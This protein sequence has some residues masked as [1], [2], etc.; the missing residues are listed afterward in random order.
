MCV[1]GRLC[2]PGEATV[3]ALDAGFLLGDGLFESLR[4]T[5]GAPYLL[6][7][8]LQRLCAAAAAL[9]F[10]HAPTAEELAEQVLRTVRH[11]ALPHAYVRVTVTRGVGGVGLAPP[12]GRPTVV[13]AALPTQPLAP[14]ERGIAVAPLGRRARRGAAKSTSWQPAVMARRQVEALGGDEGIYLSTR[15]QVS[16]GVSSNV[17]AVV[18]G[19]LLT[20]PA[21]VCL[22][23]ITRARV[24][25]LACEHG[26][27]VREAPLALDALMEA[28][29]V[30]LTNAVQ[31]LRAV[32]SMYGTGR[33]W[34][35]SGGMFADLHRLYQLDRAAAQERIA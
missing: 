8:H 6:E 12:A 18:A 7:R 30:F 31:G 28:D 34:T 17:F 1:D 2:P 22:P 3:S 11:A 21:S 23:G 5:D 25:E 24:I 14:A 27:A 15:R 10:T 19:Q 16:E 4:A 29:E 35:A 33:E 9:E 20:P 26:V 32:A 13:V